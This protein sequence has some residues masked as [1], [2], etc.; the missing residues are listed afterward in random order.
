[1]YGI[2][3][4]YSFPNCNGCTVHVWE[5]ISNFISHIIM[6]A[7]IYHC[8]N[9]C[10]SM[11]VKGVLDIY[12]VNFA[13]ETSAQFR[14]D[15]ETPCSVASRF[16]QMKSESLVMRTF[17]SLA[18][19]EIVIMTPPGFQCR[20]IETYHSRFYGLGSIQIFEKYT[21][22]ITLSAISV[23]FIW[24]WSHWCYGTLINHCLDDMLYEYTYNG[25]QVI[26]EAYVLYK[27]WSYELL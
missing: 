21:S 20:I 25:G 4:T 10:Q 8:Q 11:L 15:L 9:E 6:D 19:P 12:A 26:N 14:S 22:A 27:L 18:T 2:K 16:P 24:L 7:I 23:L 13:A 3:F 1:M 17:S 5:W